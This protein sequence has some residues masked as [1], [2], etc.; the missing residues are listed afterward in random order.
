M[1]RASAAICACNVRVPHTSVLRCGYSRHAR[2]VRFFDILTG[3]LA[4]VGSIHI[5]NGSDLGRLF[6]VVGKSSALVTAP[7]I[8][9]FTAAGVLAS[10]AQNPPALIFKRIMPDISRLSPSAYQTSP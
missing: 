5:E 2:I 7:I 9:T 3:L 1:I 8:L 6:D 4:N 10:V